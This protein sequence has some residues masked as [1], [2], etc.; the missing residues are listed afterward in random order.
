MSGI[1]KINGVLVD[2]EDPCAVY[3]ALYQAKIK[4]LAGD[5]VEE[6]SIESPVTRETVRFSPARMADIDRELRLLKT[7][8]EV[9]R[10]GRR[11][12]YAARTRIV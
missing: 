10:T 5:R 1:V 11:Q 7:A 3:Q 12:R 9:K 6:F 8:C 4:H 2:S